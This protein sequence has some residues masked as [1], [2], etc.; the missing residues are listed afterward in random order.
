[1]LNTDSLDQETIDDAIFAKATGQLFFNEGRTL[2]Q[3][4]IV[5]VDA[6]QDLDDAPNGADPVT[7]IS[8]GAEVEQQVDLN[9]GDATTALFASYRSLRI[10]EHA[11]NGLLESI[12]DNSVK[13]GLRIRFGAGS[14]H[15]R[16][17][18]S[19]PG[20]PDFVRWIGSSPALD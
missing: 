15:E 18:Q 14:S 6:L 3:G 17:A 7:I 9:F 4:D 10:E 16:A 11:N 2:V 12:T 5:Y 13:A 19:A 1:M 20:L 8:W